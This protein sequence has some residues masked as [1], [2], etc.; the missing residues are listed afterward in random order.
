MPQSKEINIDEILTRSKKQ[1]EEKKA[2]NTRII[3]SDTGKEMHGSSSKPNFDGGKAGAPDLSE[4]FQGGGFENLFANGG[5]P[6]AAAGG[7]KMSSLKQRVM[8]KLV[9]FFAKPGRIALLKNKLLWPIWAI[10]AI[11]LLIVGVIVG[12]FYLIYMVL[13]AIVSPYIN[14]FRRNKE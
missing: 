7:S 1:A 3:D 11:L 12:F 8:F 13:K 10:L 2:R 5:F 14:L 9:G 6:G 4:M